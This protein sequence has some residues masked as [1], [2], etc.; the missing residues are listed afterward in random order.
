MSE[1]A[2]SAEPEEDT[3]VGVKERLKKMVFMKKKSGKETDTAAKMTAAELAARRTARLTAAKKPDRQPDRACSQREKPDGN[4]IPKRR[5]TIKAIITAM[6]GIHT[7]KSPSTAT[8]S[9]G[10][11]DSD[12]S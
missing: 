5:S 8:S 10:R 6:I 12:G 9:G 3:A 7:K 1:E 11:G 2:A 4:W